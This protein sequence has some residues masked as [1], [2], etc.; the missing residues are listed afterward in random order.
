MMNWKETVMKLE[1]REVFRLKCHKAV[2]GYLGKDLPDI[3]LSDMDAKA[4]QI[5]RDVALEELEAQAEITW[6]IS[7]KAGYKQALD[8]ALP[9]D[10]T[11]VFENGEKTGIREV[12][13]FASKFEP[14]IQKGGAIEVGHTPSMRSK[15]EWK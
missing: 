11:D 3:K 9:V 10:L 8:E 4:I 2:A 5:C 13:E 12:V 1:Q 6:S 15:W 7:F 14:K